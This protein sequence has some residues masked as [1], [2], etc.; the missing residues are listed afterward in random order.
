MLTFLLLLLL[1]TLV[2]PSLQHSE[3]SFDAAPKFRFRRSSRAGKSEKQIIHTNAQCIV[4]FS[5]HRKNI[6]ASYQY[7]YWF[8]FY[9][10]W[11][12]VLQQTV[13]LIQG[14]T[15]HL[16][17]KFISM[18]LFKLNFFCLLNKNCYI[19]IFLHQY[20]NSQP[21]IGLEKIKTS[22]V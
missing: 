7:F 6:Q 1:W 19:G 12:S 8:I 2:C 15:I 13:S 16:K 3:E 10:Y 5:M 21:K 22:L 18:S 17:E 11:L 9:F 20:L 14:Q 4:E